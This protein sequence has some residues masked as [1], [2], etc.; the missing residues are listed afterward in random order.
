GVFEKFKI[1]LT[2]LESRPLEGQP[3]Q[4][5]FYADASLE[6]INGSPREY[7]ATVI[8]ALKDVVEDLRLLGV[9]PESRH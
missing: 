5:W 9:Y 7:V 2:R 1:N 8:D 3:W 4:Y 6:N